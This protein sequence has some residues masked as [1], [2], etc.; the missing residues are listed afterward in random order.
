MWRICPKT[1]HWELS[2]EHN[3]GSVEN[4]ALRLHVNACSISKIKICMMVINSILCNIIDIHLKYEH[5]NDVYVNKQVFQ[6]Q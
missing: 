2:S 3:W 5:K 4:Y 1:H 6:W